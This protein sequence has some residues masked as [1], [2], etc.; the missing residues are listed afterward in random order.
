M[1]I[2][3]GIDVPAAL[4]AALLKKADQD[5]EAAPASMAEKGARAIPTAG[6]QVSVSTLARTL[7]QNDR[8]VGSDFDSKKVADIKAA[9]KNG[10]FK[11]NPEAIA[12][13]MLDNAQEMLSVTR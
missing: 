7:E 11:I 13:K 4:N 1:K 10:T 6:A 12:D 5:K 8:A 3:Q 2:G 9:I